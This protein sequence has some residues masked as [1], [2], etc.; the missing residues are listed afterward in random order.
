MAK[1]YSVTYG[2]TNAMSCKLV[3][4]WWERC[5]LDYDN[6]ISANLDRLKTALDSKDSTQGPGVYAFIGCHDTVPMPHVLYIGYSQELTDEILA[7]VFPNI[8]Y[9]TTDDPRTR[10]FAEDCWDVTV[11][12]AAVANGELARL[13]EALLIESGNLAEIVADALLAVGLSSR[14]D[15]IDKYVDCQM[16]ARRGFSRNRCQVCMN[17]CIA[18]D[19][20]WPKTSEC[21]Y[22]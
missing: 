7:S 13:V 3:P 11:Y 10:Y 6:D 2:T 15:C 16:N 18:N 20:V 5:R 12:W 4:L 8:G 17:R 19:F 14:Q 21:N 9:R 1:T 22:R